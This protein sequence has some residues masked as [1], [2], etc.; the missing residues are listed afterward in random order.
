MAVFIP[1]QPKGIQGD[2]LV[3]EKLIHKAVLFLLCVFS[4]IYVT[5]DLQI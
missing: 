2:G 4:T 1:S 3:Y 5:K